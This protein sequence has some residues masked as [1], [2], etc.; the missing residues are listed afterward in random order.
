MENGF[1]GK[2]LCI[3][4]VKT[5]NQNKTLEKKIET[6]K[7]EHKLK[8]EKLTAKLEKTKHFLVKQNKEVVKP[9]LS[10]IKLS[11]EIKQRYKT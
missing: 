2:D 3:E 9:L 4:I 11:E 1:N 10:E 8:I 7:A 6:I 5:K